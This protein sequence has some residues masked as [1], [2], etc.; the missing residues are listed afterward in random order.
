[1]A[2]I[3]YLTSHWDTKS[4][5]TIQCNATGGPEWRLGGQKVGFTTRPIRHVAPTSKFQAQVLWIAK[6][7][8]ALKL[9]NWGQHTQ[10]TF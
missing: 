3:L 6:W 10:G 1:M 4:K 7:V 2:E 5:G 9:R 8:L